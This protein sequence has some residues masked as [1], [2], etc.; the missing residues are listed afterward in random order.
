[1]V[2][3]LLRRLA[4]ALLVL[5]VVATVTFG[6]VHAAPGGPSLLAD[7][8]LSVAERAAIAARLGVDRPLPEQYLRWLGALA[9]GDLGNSFLYET[10]TLST[11][12]DRLPTTLLLAGAAL[13]VT[14]LVAVPVGA[15]SAARPGGWIDRVGSVFAIS[16]ISIPVFWL[17]IVGI[18]L[19]AVHWGLLPAGGAETVGGDGSLADRLQH[20]VLPT[21]VLSAAG[22]AE[23]MRYTRA[24]AR[25]QL[26]RPFVR[27]ARA[28]GVGE[29]AVR[30]RHAMRNALIPVVTV[31]GL[32]LPRLVGGAAITE[33]VF[34]WPGMGRLGIEAALA[35]DYPLVMAI[36]LVVSGGVLL[37]S[38]LVDLA[39]LVLDPRIRLEA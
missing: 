6:I 27:T 2:A 23:L 5:F 38:L 34:A 28:K 31:L 26:A 12:G 33:T 22:T 21:L 1:M 13:L 9:R 20:L 18:L 7:P 39:Y 10:S 24:S 17:G 19:F 16:A 35:R 30:W 36:T 3:F 11:I 37:A 14:V 4:H 25:R 29:R 8:K 15:A 32:Q